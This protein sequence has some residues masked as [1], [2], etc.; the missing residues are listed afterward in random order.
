MFK[1]SLIALSIFTAV[2]ANAAAVSTLTTNGTGVDKDGVIGGSNENNTAIVISSE[3][4]QGQNSTFLNMADGTN[5]D[6]SATDA[7]GPSRGDVGNAEIA[8]TI[9]SAKLAQYA[10]LKSIRVTLTGATINPASDLKADVVA[11]A[12]GNAGDHSDIASD[13]SDVKFPAAN[14]VEF[15][16]APPAGTGADLA[17]D[18]LF[19]LSGLA[20]D[21]EATTPGTQITA[22]VEMIS[23]VGDQV[24]DTATTVLGQ[25]VSQVFAGPTAAGR[26]NNVIDVTEDRLLFTNGTASDTVTFT[27]QTQMVDMNSANLTTSTP[28]YVVKGDFSFLD[29]DGNGKLDAGMTVSANNSGEVEIAEDFQSITVTQ[30]ALAAHNG[31]TKQT[32]TQSLTIETDEETVLPVQSFTVDTS[33]T[34]SDFPGSARPFSSTGGNA[35]QWTLNGTSVNVPY[36]PVGFDNLSP[37]VEISNASI[38]ADITLEGFDQN[39]NEYGP[40][41]LDFQSKADTVT[42][43]SEAAIVD[44][45]DLTE[46]TKLSLTVTV[47]APTGVSL[48]PYYRENDVRVSLPTSQYRSVQCKASGTIS[49]TETASTTATTLNATN[50]ADRKSVV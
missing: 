47:N 44:A 10:S 15:T 31:A 50:P 19:Y 38:D 23:S 42:K 49:T 27:A 20:I 29:A 40:V 26:F 21:V 25:F 36:I 35:G 18:D 12:A 7:A 43:V 32:S 33:F 6:V 34:F 14:V 28:E 16:Y 9:G 17:E 37:N 3:G 5:Q 8:F 22:Q 41:K 11:A 45:F 30:A 1:K 39:G 13:L 24:I 48:Y 2:G 4:T 46:G